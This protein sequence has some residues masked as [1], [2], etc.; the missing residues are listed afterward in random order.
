MDL[1]GAFRLVRKSHGNVRLLVVGPDEEGMRK[2]ME[3]LCGSD[4]TGLSFR[5]FA[6]APED[7]MAASDVLC[8]PS[9]RE[10]FGIVIIE[11]AAAGIPSVGQGYMA[12]RTPL[13]T[14]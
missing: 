14:V 1:A 9:Y 4:A 10:G 3:R 11:A 8:L 6:D 2:E 5:D 13:T 7:Y 12:S